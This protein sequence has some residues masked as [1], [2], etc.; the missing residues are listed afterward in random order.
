[1]GGLVL[2]YNENAYG[3]ILADSKNIHCNIRR[4]QFIAEKEVIK[5]HVYLKIIN[6]NNIVN[7][8]YS[9][10]GKN[11]KK[12]ETSLEVSGFHHNAFSEFMSLRIGLCSIGKGQVE[13]KNF[14]YK[15][16]NNNN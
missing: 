12:V 7:M 6:I 8:Y 3:G 13:F 16:I 2:M 10:D 14:E 1:M 11:W 9:L 15:K 4:W 5:N